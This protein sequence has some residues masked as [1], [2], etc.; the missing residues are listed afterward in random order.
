MSQ[1]SS[2][3]ISRHRAESRASPQ[4]ERFQFLIAEIERVRRAR[5]AWDATVL[6][7][8]QTEVARLQPLKLQLRKITR[9]TVLRIDELL[10]QPGWSRVDQVALK[11]MLRFHAKMLLETD[12]SDAELKAIFDKHGPSFDSVMRE[13][14]EDLKEH[15]AE[16]MGVDLDEEDIRSEEDLI[17]RVYRHMAERE[18]QQEEERE[19]R[20]K[21]HKKSAAQQRAEANAESAKK[22]LREIY[23]KLASAVHPDR[24][25]DAARRA[26]KNELMQRI[27]RAY[28][29]NDLLT[30]L[31]AQMRL[32]QIDPDHVAS[33]SA[34]RLKYYNKL[35]S[36]QLEGARAELRKLEDAFRADYG[37]QFEK[38]L[39]PQTLDMVIRY[40]AREI[41]DRIKEQKHFMELLANKSVVKRWLKEQRAFDRL[42]GDE[43][44]E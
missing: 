41:R 7:F 4:Q 42:F 14:F 13:D 9:D 26:E 33:L 43:N 12:S 2:L 34:E 32:Q 10:D 31:E 44:D 40:R 37:L 25:A 36:E 15:A 8:K 28:A 23:R 38:R 18:R 17:E 21:R 16:F 29:T 27:N 35:L 39:T 24:E 20:A 6:E 3:Q 30:L 11:D 5:A 1:K 22:F 19:A